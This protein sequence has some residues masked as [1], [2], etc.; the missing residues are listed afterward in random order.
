MC[1]F[2]PARNANG[3]F[4]KNSKKSYVGYGYISV[5]TALPQSVHWQKSIN[6]YLVLIWKHEMKEMA[7]NPFV[8]SIMHV[9]PRH[10]CTQK[11][12]FLRHIWQNPCYGFGKIRNGGRHHLGFRHMVTWL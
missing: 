10:A 12:H 3:T 11:L 1:A 8:R 7:W 4:R 2:L 6:F 5:A 9:G